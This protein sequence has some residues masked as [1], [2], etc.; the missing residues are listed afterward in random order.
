MVRITCF[1]YKNNLVWHTMVFSL[2]L[3]LTAILANGWTQRKHKPFWHRTT[4]LMPTVGSTTAW[5]KC[6][7]G[8]K[9]LM[10]MH[11][12][13]LF[14][15]M[16]DTRILITDTHWNNISRVL[17]P[18]ERYCSKWIGLLTKQLYV[19]FQLPSLCCVH[20]PWFH[21]PYIFHR[22]FGN[23][24]V[25]IFGLIFTLKLQNFSSSSIIP[26]TM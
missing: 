11:C 8:C 21:Y 19:T 3:S 23:F 22:T 12:C 18:G 20:M 9:G 1:W 7:K 2:L 17:L 6:V 24:M 13:M 15:V 26:A 16:L 4:N 25:Y 14:L 5:H 10:G